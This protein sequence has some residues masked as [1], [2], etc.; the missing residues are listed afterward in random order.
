MKLFLP[1]IVTFFPAIVFSQKL[2]DPVGQLAFVYYQNRQTNLIVI[3]NI[4]KLNTFKIYRRSINDSTFVQVAKKK[5]TPLPMRYNIS[6]YSVS[7]E[8]KEYHSKEV[9]Y[10]IIAFDKKGNEI[11]K[12]NVI[13]EKDPAKNP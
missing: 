7:W 1:L 6:P 3:P 5:K 4:D 13:W 8:D 12:L 10:E 2:V 11:C 9:E